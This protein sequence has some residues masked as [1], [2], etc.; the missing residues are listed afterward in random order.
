MT[1]QIATEA[2]ILRGRTVQSA[3]RKG[4]GSTATVKEAIAEGRAGVIVTPR[5]GVVGTVYRIE[6]RPEAPL[7]EC[8]ELRLNVL[9]GECRNWNGTW[10]GADVRVRVRALVEQP[11]LVTWSHARGAILTDGTVP[12]LSSTLWQILLAETDY[13]FGR[14]GG[15]EIDSTSVP[16][17]A[18]VFAALQWAVEANRSALLGESMVNRF[19]TTD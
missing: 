7:T 11:D 5:E 8:E 1:I 10:I 16:T 14:I 15:G 18:E 9:L 6:G 12:G 3:A 19:G 13:R 2:G 4:Y 17:R